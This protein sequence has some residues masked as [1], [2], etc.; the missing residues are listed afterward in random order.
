MAA[1]PRAARW[2]QIRVA[3]HATNPIPA[4]ESKHLRNEGD[5]SR[6]VVGPTIRK[7]NSRDDAAIRSH[8]DITSE[9]PEEIAGAVGRQLFE[10][11]LLVVV[12]HMARV[13]LRHADAKTS[14]EPARIAAG[15]G[16]SFFPSHRLCPFFENLD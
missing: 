10:V 14:L 4:R 7:S 16:I 12:A 2:R 8:F 3:P 11:C 5:Q 9:L 13:M 15:F 6:R 1:V